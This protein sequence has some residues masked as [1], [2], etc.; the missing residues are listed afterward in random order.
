[1]PQEKKLVEYL[2]WVTAELH[3]TKSKLAD[4]EAAQRE[5][6]AI[7]S[8]ACRFPGG[9]RSAADLWRVVESGVDTIADFPIDRGW[10][11]DSI[12]DA[13]PGHQRLGGFLGGAAD[14][15][16]AFF[17]IGP[18]E[19]TAMDPQH[20]VLLET[21]WEAVESAGIDPTSLR[22]SSTGVFAGLV[23]QNYAAHD[24]PKEFDGH[25][26]TG[27]ATSVASGRVAYTLG[28]RGPALTIDTACSSSL[29]A[30]HLAAQ[31]LRRG[32]C[33]LALAGGV[34]IMATPALL[35]E[36]VTQGGL[37]PDARCKAFAEGA[38]GTGFAE[39]VGVLLLERLSDAR[40]NGHTVLAV[41]RGS[42]VNQDGASNGL[43]A[44][45]GPAQEDVI[46]AALADAGL[47]PSDVDVVEAH[48]TGT[49]L[50]DPI[51]AGALLA[52][53]GQD[54]TDPL[55][56]GSLKSNIGHTQAAAGVAGVIK[57]IE[58][59][60]HGVL[61]KTLHVDA[62]SSNVDWSA[63]AVELLTE[64]RPWPRSERP[65]RGGV[66][67]F[68]ISGTNAHVVIEEGDPEPAPA[69]ASAG[70]VP[71]V[72]SAKTEAALRDQ[73]VRL[74]S[75]LGDH[76][77]L[78]PGD[79][80][81]SL[82]TTRTTFDHRA[83]VIAD[84]RAGLLRGLSALATGEPGVLR[85]KAGSGKTAFLFSGQG[86][87]R[88][89]MG[90]ELSANP[91]F[92][93]AWREVSAEIDKH[94]DRPLAEVVAS[95]LVH[96]TAY[97]QPALFAI[98]VALFRL[99]THW[100]L[101]PDY[102]LGHSVGELAAAHV[103]G[104][105]PL[106]DA[107]ALVVARG[108]LMQSAPTGAMVSIRASEDEVAATIAGREHAVSIA[109]VNGPLSTVVSGDVAVVDEIAAHWAAAG[110]KTARLRVSHA[111]HS[112]HLD[113]ILSEFR[114][115]A[116]SLQYGKA[117][118]PVVSNL[119]GELAD[120]STPDY[121]VRH[122]RHAV[123]FADGVAALREAGVRTFVELGPDAVLT[124]M[125][126]ES[127]PGRDF[128]LIPILRRDQPETLTAATAVAT[129]HVRGSSVDWRT[130]FGEDGSVVPLPTYAFQH[131]S[132]WLPSPSRAPL[133]NPRAEINP[134]QGE[135]D[136]FDLVRSHA[137]AVL[138]HDAPTSIN[139]DDNFT[140]IGF[141]SFTALEVRNRLS[142]ATSLALP[143]LVIYDHPTP[144]T[145]VNY[146]RTELASRP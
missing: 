9:V 110:R 18:R 118:I 117:T 126:Q 146:L 19:A 33:T 38:D 142:E 30:L 120:L 21:A 10:V 45:H 111:F 90:Q 77:D 115:V 49:R 129:A 128:A 133:P 139:D 84:D 32:E 124:A 3:E 130:F 27:N 58:A 64:S 97:T 99:L 108:A 89:G 7:I 14:F 80:G 13:A 98:E 60:R 6:I 103:A 34:T 1:M 113:G 87:Q 26:M 40:R 31:A 8:T 104:V 44:P 39:G 36:F 73:A 96:Q 29:V 107:S 65:R 56:L 143:A 119:T 125:A 79:V 136:L 63:G 140:D 53:Y 82:V 100:G 20:R 66:S 24:T 122:V 2:K 42:A 5:P 88:V 22:G 15:D 74:H 92:G 11:T 37:S 35:A 75:Y 137:A 57:I 83:A 17:G 68:G 76:P 141:S 25:L 4:I 127:L 106:A 101:R 86:S 28:L 85:G 69:A 145:L 132:F 91:V 54:R 51:E 16:A 114:A 131:K 81:F 12:Y 93:E 59:L 138:G 135:V 61:P 52:T 94:L 23:S 78:S 41:L 50:G 55:R 43:T 121:W 46:R 116:E 144:A 109:A 123:R 105:L 134:V 62:P 95:E 47:R 72:I 71:W 70:V 48:G 67:S 102:L 112:P